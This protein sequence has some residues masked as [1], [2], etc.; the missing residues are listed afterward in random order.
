ME[1]A[2][3]TIHLS[4]VTTINWI[5]LSTSDCKLRRSAGRRG[6][7]EK[8]CGGSSVGPHRTHR[9]IALGLPWG[10]EDRGGTIVG[11]SGDVLAS[12]SWFCPG[13]SVQ[14]LLCLGGSD[15]FRVWVVYSGCGFLV[16][17]AALLVGGR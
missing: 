4:R 2:E 7:E 6:G 17:G 16:L 14:W 10:H 3:P 13:M 1:I 8:L 9:W 5:G 15:Q 11:V 12:R